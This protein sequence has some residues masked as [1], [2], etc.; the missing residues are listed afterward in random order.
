MNFKQFFTESQ[1]ISKWVEILD[2]TSEDMY[3]PDVVKSWSLIRHWR[4]RGETQYFFALDKD[5]YYQMYDEE[6]ND[7]LPDEL[8]KES[9][10]NAIKKWEFKNSLTP[11]TKETFGD[12]I[13]EL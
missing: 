5:G 13:D 2:I 7:L 9:Y 10:V 3:G 11:Q 6:G 4:H 8:E 12:I 1:D